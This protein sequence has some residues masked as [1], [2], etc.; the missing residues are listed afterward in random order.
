MKRLFFIV[1]ISMFCLANVSAQK[2]VSYQSTQARALEPNMNAYVH[3][4][5]VE[6]K[7]MSETRVVD[8]WPITVEQIAAFDGKEEEIRKYGL[9]K[10]CEKHN[11]DVIVAATFNIQSDD[12]SKGLM[13][14]IVGYP[15][16][17]VNWKTATQ[18]DYEWI[19]LE[20]TQT[21]SER[22]KVS[23]VIK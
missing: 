16:E 21:T 18:A 22:E 15:G 23:A 11:C 14:D 5:T 20:K 7:I 4:L 12:M 8:H 10:S 13:L 2:V 17:Y 1:C 19:K 6:L 9:Y 3:P